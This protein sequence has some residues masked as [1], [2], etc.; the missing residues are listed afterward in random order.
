[1]PYDNDGLSRSADPTAAKNF[2]PH[3]TRHQLTTAIPTEQCAHCH[4][5]GGRIGLAYRGI[6]EGGFSP[7]NTPAN[8]VSLGVPLHAHDANFYFV[9]EDGTNSDDKNPTAD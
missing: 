8:A 1:M 3:P 7:Q 6:R 4:F 9:D 2:P 5:Q